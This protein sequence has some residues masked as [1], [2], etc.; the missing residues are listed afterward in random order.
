VDVACGLDHTLVV[1]GM[2]FM[3]REAMDLINLFYNIF[4]LMLLSIFVIYCFDYCLF[5]SVYS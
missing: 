1:T 3:W 2:R 5:A 4:I